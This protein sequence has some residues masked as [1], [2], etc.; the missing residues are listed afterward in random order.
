MPICIQ[1]TVEDFY[2]LKSLYIAAKKVVGW[3]LLWLLQECSIEWRIA[4]FYLQGFYLIE[5]PFLLQKYSVNNQRVYYIRRL[6]SWRFLHIV[7]DMQVRK[8]IVGFQPCARGETWS[9]V[10]WLILLRVT[11]RKS[12][13]LGVTYLYPFISCI[14]RSTTIFF[15]LS[16]MFIYGWPNIRIDGKWSE[17][18]G[19]SW[20]N[21]IRW[22]STLEAGVIILNV[23]KQWHYRAIL[24][25]KEL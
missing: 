13:M 9:N 5:H 2:L 25:C 3:Y 19:V 8:T 12:D 22:R 23:R 4:Q 10:M 21:Y 6:L 20:R 15:R 7:W 11:S 18:L 17:I 14:N 16:H 24:T 1:T